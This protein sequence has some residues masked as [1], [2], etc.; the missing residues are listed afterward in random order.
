MARR[1]AWASI[2]YGYCTPNSAV[3]CP[4]GQ[5]PTWSRAQV[6]E[7]R[8]RRAYA[9]RPFLNMCRLFMGDLNGKD[10]GIAGGKLRARDGD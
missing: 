10:S 8:A 4:N 3:P 1:L 6:F 2:H 7:E 5:P 9:E